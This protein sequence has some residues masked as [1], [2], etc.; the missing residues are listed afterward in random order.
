MKYGFVIA[1]LL[2][3][4]STMAEMKLSAAAAPLQGSDSTQMVSQNAAQMD[5]GCLMMGMRHDAMG[6]NP[7][8][9]RCREHRGAFQ[10]MGCCPA[11]FMMHHPMFHR[12]IVLKVFAGMFFLCFL[13]F[14]TVNVLLTVLVS[15]DMKKRGTFN[16]LWIPLLIIA[17]IPVSAIYALFRIGDM[18]TKE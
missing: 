12:I 9:E 8:G 6:Q 4:G 2:M 7:M 17:G 18:R 14:A 15:L 3:A 10:G 13:L 16:G 1:I 11:P 5:K